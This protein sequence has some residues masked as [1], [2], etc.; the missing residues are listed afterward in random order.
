[1][2]FMLIKKQ[3]AQPILSIDVPGVVKASNIQEEDAHPPK[4]VI[5]GSLVGRRQEEKETIGLFFFL[6]MPAAYRSPQTLA[7]AV[8]RATAVTMVD[9][10]PAEP[11]G[12]SIS[13]FLIR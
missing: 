10:Q 7:A 11:A 13:Y 8:T 12:N 1:M 5:L 3:R 4:V 6:A 2:R 9:P